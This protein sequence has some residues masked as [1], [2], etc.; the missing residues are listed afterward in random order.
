MFYLNVIHDDWYAQPIT[1]VYTCSRSLAEAPSGVRHLVGV[2]IGLLARDFLGLFS[3][4][5]ECPPCAVTCGSLCPPVHCTTGHI[6][7]SIF[8][9]VLS[10]LIL[11]VTGLGIWWWRRRSFG[12]QGTWGSEAAVN[13]PLSSDVRRPL[14]SAIAWRPEGR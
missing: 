8:T 3:S 5:L 2:A 7:F 4:K 13:K 9:L 14:G 11:V 12:N 1:V 6:E 10:G